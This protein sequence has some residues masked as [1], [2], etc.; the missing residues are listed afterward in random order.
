MKWISKLFALIIFKIPHGFYPK[1]RSEHKK[2][3][4]IP[5]NYGEYLYLV[6]LSGQSKKSF[7]DL[8]RQKYTTKTV[9]HGTQ[10]NK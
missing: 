10:G 6:S 8:L 9:P 1:Q 2:D 4:E 3:N 7:A 5:M